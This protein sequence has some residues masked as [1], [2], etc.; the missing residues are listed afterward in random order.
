[1]SGHCQ[2]LSCARSSEKAAWSPPPPTWSQLSPQNRSP[3][4]RAPKSIQGARWLDSREPLGDKQKQGMLVAKQPPCWWHA[5]RSQGEAWATCLRPRRALP[6]TPL[7][8]RHPQSTLPK[9]L[10][11]QAFSHPS[12]RP[13]LCAWQHFPVGLA[14][15]PSPLGPQVGPRVLTSEP[16]HPTPTSTPRQVGPIHSLPGP[17]APMA[18][19]LL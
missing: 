17:P 19:R 6:A 5:E 15:H 14:G 4:L 12:L 11:P 8:P 9:S 2:I 10:H 13:V 3:G 18:T 16:P 1:M 7:G